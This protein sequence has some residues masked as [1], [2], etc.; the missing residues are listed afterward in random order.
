MALPSPEELQAMMN[1]DT[2]YQSSLGG[3]DILGGSSLGR[4]PSPSQLQ[5]MMIA[6][7]I[8][9]DAGIGTKAASGALYGI[10]TMGDLVDILSKG[11][12]YITPD[13]VK[14]TALTKE[15]PVNAM[16]K[17]ENNPQG[18]VG[19]AIRNKFD[20]LTGVKNSTQIGSDSLP[21][22][23]GSYAPMVLMGGENLL[24][25]GLKSAVT[26]E[27]AKELALGLGK[28][29]AQTALAGTGG[30][31]GRQLGESTGHGDLGEFIG[32]VGASMA[33]SVAN[34]LTKVATKTFF[35]PLSEDQA[36]LQAFKANG[37]AEDLAALKLLK[38]KGII[39]EEFLASKT[40]FTNIDEATKTAITN[41]SSDI[42]AELA[43]TSAK[44][45][46]LYPTRGLIQNAEKV[47]ENHIASALKQAQENLDKKALLKLY[48]GQEDNISNLY[49]YYQNLWTKAKGGSRKA[50]IQYADLTEKM[51]NVKFSGNELWDIRQFYDKNINWASDTLKGQAPVWASLRDDLQ[52]KIVGLAGG[53]DSAVSKGF[54]DL[55]KMFGIQDD[56]SKLANLELA[57]KTQAA[58]IGQKLAGALV[59]PFK[60]AFNMLEAG[61]RPEDLLSQAFGRSIP[62][63]V[64]NNST[65]PQRIGA[66]ITPSFAGL[67]GIGGSDLANNQKPAVKPQDNLGI[68]LSELTKSTQGP[69]VMPKADDINLDKLPENKTDRVSYV[70]KLIDSDPVDAAIYKIESGRNPNAK[71]PESTASG[72]FQL[73]KRTASKLGVEN[74]F[75]IAENYKGFLKLKEENQKVLRSLGLDENDPESI[76]SLHYLGAP[77]Y[78]KWVTGGSLT[79]EQKAQISYLENKV[80]PK[81][82]K[83]YQQE[84]KKLVEV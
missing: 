72:A 23:I 11:M 29:G 44:T 8:N 78:K 2:G 14:S 37:G 35:P 28:A 69:T 39:S 19:Q 52:N 71:N 27:G 32:S 6:D 84:V 9:K 70:E 76:Y 62:Q 25:N 66:A 47:G 67:L 79:A 46:E 82:L 49:N 83:T 56:V 10:S 60:Q 7:Q 81:F 75:D 26:T 16:L 61:S 13:F 15:N 63:R 5:D 45:S 65:I 3:S 17:A 36:L 41:T 43:T 31:A 68:S 73:L 20:D 77:T 51:Q 64:L 55:S 24:T 74:V 18:M 34:G 58:P 59:R 54:S 57:G 33:P 30:Y 80:L 22:K 40:P 4:L 53:T 42:G 48:P 38:D 50:A 12:D 1:S 21:Y